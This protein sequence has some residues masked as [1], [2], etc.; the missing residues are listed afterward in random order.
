[1]KDTRPGDY[2]WFEWDGETDPTYDLEDENSIIYYTEEWVELDNDLV[3]RAL[4]SAL[5]KDGVV[6]SLGDG[7]K[8][9]EQSIENFYWTYA[10]YVD[11]VLHQCDSSDETYYGDI[12]EK[13]VK[14]TFIKIYI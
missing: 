7:F 10:G 5:Q 12:V 6:S 9:V 8:S 14:I 11:E 4:A 3:K 13:T 2:L 1:L